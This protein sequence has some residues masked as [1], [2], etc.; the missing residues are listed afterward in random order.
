[1]R[2]KF[3]SEK[4]ELEKFIQFSPNSF[5]EIHFK[6][7]EARHQNDVEKQIALHLLLSIIYFEKDSVNQATLH[8]NQALNLYK[9]SDVLV[10]N[11]FFGKIAHDI[12]TTLQSQTPSFDIKKFAL[13]ELEEKLLKY[14]QNGPKSKFE[15]IDHL[16]NE[17]SDILACENRLKNLFFRIRTKFPG[18]I[19]NKK[20][21]Y[22]IGRLNLLLLF[23]FTLFFSFIPTASKAENRLC[24]NLNSQISTTSY[25]WLVEVGSEYHDDLNDSLMKIKGVGVLVNFNK[26]FFI[27]SDAHLTQGKNTFY[28]LA[29]KTYTQI[30]HTAAGTENWI[31]NNDSDVEIIQIEEPEILN[32]PIFSYNINKDQFELEEGYDFDQKYISEN[33]L[34]VGNGAWSPLP[35]HLKSMPLCYTSSYPNN[36]SVGD[37]SRQLNGITFNYMFQDQ[38]SDSGVVPGMSGTPLLARSTQNNKIIIGGLAKSRHR[39]FPKS[40]FSIGYQ[41][42]ALFKNYLFGGIK[43]GEVFPIKGVV[44]YYGRPSQTRWRYKT[45]IGTYL[46]F[47]NGQVA[48]DT[49]WKIHAGGN[50]TGDVG[51][52]ETGDVGSINN[53]RTHSLTELNLHAGMTY[54]NA[55]A[56][57]FKF[58]KPEMHQSFAIYANPQALLYLDATNGNSFGHP[59]YEKIKDETNIISLFRERATSRIIPSP[60]MQNPIECQFSQGA[61]VNGKIQLTLINQNKLYSNQLVQSKG[62]STNEI[63]NNESVTISLNKHGILE[64]SQ[65]NRFEPI[66]DIPLEDLNGKRRKLII[67]IKGLFFTDLSYSETPT[68]AEF[69]Q[70]ISPDINTQNPQDTYLKQF[71]KIPSVII[72]WPEDRRDHPVPCVR[73]P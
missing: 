14:I 25:P 24:Y 39:W 73:G 1:M 20:G 19:I 9:V 36:L 4:I 59:A 52:N 12:K 55:P 6:I 5:A 62:T 27:V 70:H 69:N 31:A 40:Y 65:F 15:I 13:S 3:L 47:G 58:T 2:N 44:D 23:A 22:A 35:P 41:I 51:G 11:S 16:Y 18:L 7:Q 48:I 8:V 17:Q 43:D 30:K 50:E 32:H 21:L 34:S 38:V 63:K 28:Q 37:P 26:R 60:W 53:T 42:S 46:D 29:G 54:E 64:N 56:L 45:N 68:Y 33:F 10:P 49:S 72:K 66:F 71:G 57:A 67:D 61:L